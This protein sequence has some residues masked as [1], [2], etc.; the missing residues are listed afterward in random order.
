MIAAVYGM[1]RI[2]EPSGLISTG[3]TAAA[4]LVTYAAGYLMLAGAEEHEF[5]RGVLANVRSAVSLRL[6]RSGARSK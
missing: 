2:L 5:I 4:G 3:V 1:G 6:N